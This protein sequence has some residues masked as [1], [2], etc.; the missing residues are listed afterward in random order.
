MA[1]WDKIGFREKKAV[2][3]FGLDQQGKMTAAMNFCTLRVLWTLDKH[4]QAQKIRSGFLSLG[5][6]FTSQY[7]QLVPQGKI[8]KD[9]ISFIPEYEVYKAENKFC[10]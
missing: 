2:W 4:N 10:Y 1:F 5:F 6:F 8:L 3:F 9:K 7:I